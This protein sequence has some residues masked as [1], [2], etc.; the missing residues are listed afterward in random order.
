MCLMRA[1]ISPFPRSAWCAAG[2]RAVWAWGQFLAHATRPVKRAAVL[3]HFTAR[4]A[5]LVP[6]ATRPPLG[7]HCDHFTAR[8]AALVPAATRPPLGSHCDHFTARLAALV[9][10]A[11][12]P[13]LASHCSRRR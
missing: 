11:P 9:P 13:P 8:L 3:D 10:A 5:A 4:L 6:A 1:M 7:S 12:R 2:A